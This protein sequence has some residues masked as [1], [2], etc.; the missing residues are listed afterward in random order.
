MVNILDVAKLAGVSPATVSRVLNNGN[1]VSLETQN[2]VNS[3]IKTLR[4]YPNQFS[5]KLRKQESKFL[6]ILIPDFKNPFF[7]PVLRGMDEAACTLGYKLLV[8]PTY[9]KIEKEENMNTLLSSKFADGAILTMPVIS[10]EELEKLARK[11]PIVQCCEYIPDISVSHVSI[12]NFDAAYQVMSY[13]LGKGHKKIAILSVNKGYVSKEREAACFKALEDYNMDCDSFVIKRG[14]DYSFEW[15]IALTQELLISC[16]Q[17]TAIFAFSDSLACGCMRVLS[18][19]GYKIP[20]EIEIMG[21]DNINVAVMVTPSL[22]TVAQPMI[23]IGK[24]AVNMLISQINGKS[25]FHEQYLAH[26][27]ILRQ[28]TK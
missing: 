3:A 5:Q 23:A 10:G 14:D 18:E 4:Y 12:N 27:V 7:G 6:L 11:F 21:F 13:F 8:S 26:E 28:T 25:E 17:P 2:K 20:S 22:S 9:L 19:A 1:L 15:G 16:D 24:A